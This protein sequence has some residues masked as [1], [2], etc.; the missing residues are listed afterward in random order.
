MIRPRRLHL[1]P[2]L[3]LTKEVISDP[4][5]GLLPQAVAAP[6]RGNSQGT[7]TRPT[8]RV[9]VPTMVIE[10]QSARGIRLEAIAP[11]QLGDSI[12]IAS[13]GVVPVSPRWMP[14]RLD[15]VPMHGPW[16]RS[17]QMPYVRPVL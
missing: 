2:E 9:I 12:G 17:P 8:D 15:Q 13:P 16:E 3:P 5:L 1:H 7:E 14:S 11:G 10:I 4:A 6:T